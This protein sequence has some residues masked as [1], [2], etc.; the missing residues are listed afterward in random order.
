MA[1]V[2]ADRADA[3]AVLS[4]AEH[5]NFWVGEAPAGIT[6]GSGQAAFVFPGQGSQHVGMARGLYDTEPVCSAMSS[7]WCA[8]GFG[9][10]LGI[11][12]KAEVFDG[13]SLESTDP[14]SLHGLLWNTRW[15]AL[16]CPSA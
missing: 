10:E 3:A 5:D 6:P 9:A 7:T 11:D 4:A 14:L 1:A 8:V 16:S 12:L 15:R 2:V 13:A